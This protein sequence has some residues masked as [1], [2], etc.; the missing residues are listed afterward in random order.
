LAACLTLGRACVGI[1]ARADRNSVAS[2]EDP[3]SEPGTV[4]RLGTDLL[5]TVGLP[6]VLGRGIML[7]PEAG[8]GGGRL[9]STVV[10]SMP[11][12]SD[13]SA[14]DPPSEKISWGWRS[15]TRV[16]LSIPVWWRLALDVTGAFDTS[17]GNGITKPEDPGQ[18]AVP[19][20][21]RF[22]VRG[23]VALRYRAP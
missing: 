7:M 2:L 3:G 13:P 10:S 22:F 15:T 8:L 21:P 12:P 4:D 19:A 9:R 23:G 1:L 18:A 11:D 17:F 5:A 14:Q 6:I 20:D 16:V